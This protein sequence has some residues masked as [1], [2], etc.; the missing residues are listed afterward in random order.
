MS[1]TLTTHGG[2]V[3]GCRGFCKNPSHR[4]ENTARGGPCGAA[5]D[6]GVSHKLSLDMDAG[7]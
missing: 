5:Q 4:I 6:W 7:M 3:V 2:C 1:G